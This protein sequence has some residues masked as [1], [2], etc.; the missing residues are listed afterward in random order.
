[1]ASPSNLKTEKEFQRAKVFDAESLIKEL[2]DMHNSVEVVTCQNDVI[3]INKN[4]DIIIMEVQK[5][6]N[7]QL[8]TVGS[9]GR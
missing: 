6:G 8:K 2:G 7:D 9:R 1:M 5:K 4:S 3:N